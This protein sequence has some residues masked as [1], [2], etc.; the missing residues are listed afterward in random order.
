MAD[1]KRN[2]EQEAKPLPKG[3]MRLSRLGGLVAGS[4]L[5]PG[6]VWGAPHPS[7]APVRQ[8]PGIH[9]T[10]SQKKYLSNI[11]RAVRL[12]IAQLRRRGVLSASDRTSIV[13]FGLGSNKHYV[14]INPD[15]PRMAAS[16]IKPFIMLAAYHRLAHG[17]RAPSGLESSI[18][19]MIAHSDNHAANRV[20][21][22]VG[23][24]KAANAIVRR[25]GF[26]KTRIV[27]SIPG[28]GK[29]YRNRTSARNLSALLW[30]LHRRRLV[31]P[32]FSARML[33]H[34]NDYE[35]SRLRRLHSLF[36]MDLTGKT[37]FVS[38]ENGEATR[39]TFSGPNGG[40]AD[41]NFVVLIENPNMPGKPGERW[42]H[43]TS[44]AI[45]EIFKTVHENMLKP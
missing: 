26:S 11:D 22:F 6:L 33:G 17:A 24:P 3:R 2:E 44:G 35:T 20:L 8:L 27:E 43:R 41:Y 4:L 12:K 40:N 5:L 31:S 37:G 38:G 9:R 16:L 34:L 10:V 19:E 45:R 28:S 25:Y 32:A 42:G 15:Q 14:E 1:A 39:V 18:S 29:T 7:S 23:G 13:V 36:D 30:Q 21:R